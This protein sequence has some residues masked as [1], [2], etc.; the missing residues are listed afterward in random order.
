MMECKTIT[1]DPMIVNPCVSKTINVIMKLIKYWGSE[2]K[3]IMILKGMSLPFISS[4]LHIDTQSN[5][6]K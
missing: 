3:I 1:N 2:K 4:L 5:A 6:M